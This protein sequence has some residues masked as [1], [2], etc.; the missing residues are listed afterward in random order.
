[1]RKSLLLL[2]A[3][4]WTSPTWAADPDE[5][6]ES[7]ESEDAES[8]EESEGDGGDTAAVSN[9]TDSRVEVATEAQTLQLSPYLEE[10]RIPLPTGNEP[11]PPPQVVEPVAQPPAD[12]EEPTGDDRPTWETLEPDEVTRGEIEVELPDEDL[13]DLPVKKKV[14]PLYPDE[15][16]VLYGDRA[17]RCTARVNV[18]DKGN[19]M[20]A[21][22]VQCADGFHLSALSALTKW[23]WDVSKDQVVPPEGLLVEV[24]MGF[25]RKEKKFFPGVTY[26]TTP[27]EVTADPRRP[28][29]LASGTMPAYPEQV[30]HGDAECRVE[31]TVTDKGKTKDVLVDECAAPYR[32]EAEKAVKKWKWYAA[33]TAKGGDGRT[34]T[35]V[36]TISFKLASTVGAEEL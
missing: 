8:S 23:R 31:V 27:T 22:M 36:F 30:R 34:S 24:E 20:R 2:A 18:D 17:I 21:A 1:M 35:A 9:T 5:S 3:L 28:A 29:L 12:V 10:R 19:P 7:S 15:L 25:L 32:V 26:F 14:L 16:S 33:G 11:P 6:E 13:M 4:T